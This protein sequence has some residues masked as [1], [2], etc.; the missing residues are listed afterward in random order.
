MAPYVANGPR[1]AKAQKALFES[2]ERGMDGVRLKVRNI[3]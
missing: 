1:A 2:E 3:S